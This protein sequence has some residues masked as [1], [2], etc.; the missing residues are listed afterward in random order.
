M[1]ARRVTLGTLHVLS[2]GRGRSMTSFAIQ[3][4]SSSLA[5]RC[6]HSVTSGATVLSGNLGLGR[7]SL[8]KRAGRSL[9]HEVPR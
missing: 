7:E 6:M 2:Q 5:K 1:E 9:V 8:E 4:V 3:Q